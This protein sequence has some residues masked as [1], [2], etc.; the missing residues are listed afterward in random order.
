MLYVC[1]G[2]NRVLPNFTCGISH[3]KVTVFETSCAR[4]PDHW[5]VGA[6]GAL[7][8]EPV[9]PDGTA[10]ETKTT[11]T[12]SS[13]SGHMASSAFQI[14]PFSRLF[15]HQRY[16]LVLLLVPADF[17]CSPYIL[18]GTEPQTSEHFSP[19]GLFQGDA[20]QPQSVKCPPGVNDAPEQDAG[21]CRASPR[22]S[23]HSLSWFAPCHFLQAPPCSC[24]IP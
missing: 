23:S 17:S 13:L 14:A 1:Y 9:I 6:A 10:I 20:V 21:P 2:L 5:T 19:Y 15:P 18:E 7:R 22:T 24:D 16:F 3:P 4:I 8:L 11:L 12:I